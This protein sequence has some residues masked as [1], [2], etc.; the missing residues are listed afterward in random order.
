MQSPHEKENCRKKKTNWEKAFWSFE[1]WYWGFFF[2]VFSC[3]PI[4]KIFNG[5]FAF[6]DLDCRKQFEHILPELLELCMYLNTGS[7]DALS[8][9]MST[10]KAYQTTYH[11]CIHSIL[12]ILNFLETEKDQLKIAF[13]EYLFLS[14]MRRI[15]TILYDKFILTGFKKYLLSAEAAFML[16]MNA[17]AFAGVYL[18]TLWY[19]RGNMFVVSSYMKI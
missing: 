16:F 9:S 13:L 12:L 11:Q 17:A 15:G 10:A 4:T 3:S 2:S 6:S 8:V 14:F 7:L 19:C 1:I 18:A 5:K